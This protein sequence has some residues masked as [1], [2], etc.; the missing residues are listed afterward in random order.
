MAIDGSKMQLPNDPA[1][2]EAFVGTGAGAK[3]PTAQASFLYN[4]LNDIVVDA[5]LAPLST[6]ERTLAKEHLMALSR[7]NTIK[8]KL[9]LFDRGYP[10]ADLIAALQASHCDFL[11]RVR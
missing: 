11:F 6:D 8:K 3:V 10:C 2:L 9:I 7:L 4:P 5:K 1:L